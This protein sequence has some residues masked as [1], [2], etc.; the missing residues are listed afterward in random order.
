MFGLSLTKILF[1]VLLIV[2]VWR[3][4]KL[5]E[6][7]K[8]TISDDDETVAMPRRRTTKPR[9]TTEMVRCPNCGTYNPQGERCD[10]GS[11]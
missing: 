11:A 5:F 6:R 4:F 3:G 9:G 7:I 8:N 2:A 1:T 10:C